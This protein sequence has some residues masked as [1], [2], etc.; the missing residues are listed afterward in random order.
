MTDQTE[1][2]RLFTAVL[3]MSVLFACAATFII[4]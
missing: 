1:A 2:K 4:L 3:V